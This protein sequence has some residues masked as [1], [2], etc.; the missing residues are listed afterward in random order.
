MST[1]NQP[2]D[3]ASASDRDP[4]A[5]S[6][7]EAN[8]RIAARL[9]QLKGSESVELH[10]ALGRF[11]RVDLTS[12]MHSPPF[13][14]S[15]MD[16]YAY[17]F[18]DQGTTRT[19]V[20]TSLAGHPAQN[21][22]APGDCVR[23]TTGAKIPDDADTVVQQENTSI[24]NDQLNMINPPLKSGHHVRNIGS[25]CEKGR[26]I[27]QAGTRVNAGLLGLCAALGVQKLD[28]LSQ[29]RVILLSTGDELK[30]GGETLAD[31]Q[32]FDANTPLLTA[33]FDDPNVRVTV[34]KPIKDTPESVHDS[35]THAAAN[36]D[37][38]IT[39]GGVSVGERDH[40]RE[41]MENRG[42]VDLWKVAMKPGRPLSFGVL[43]GK[44]PWF[45]LPG[46]PVSAALTALLF[47]M[48]ALRHCQGL[49]AK[50][51]RVI[52]AVCKDRLEKLPGRVEFQR[53]RLETNSDG[54]VTVSTTGLQDSHILSSLANANCLIRLPNESLGAASGDTVSVIPFE[55]LNQN[56]V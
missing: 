16:G 20:A 54:V 10:E 28:V 56:L 6:I 7:D 55:F 36:A 12:P 41:V 48:P 47:V 50:P 53:G 9:A 43:D 18:S 29:I 44:T 27:A 45:G 13:R 25:D 52:Q 17:R 30:P 40:L 3:N 33:L 46:N 24:D 26:C 2:T 8:T 23:V 5:V 35:L 14:A 11:L 4:N 51:L 38:I 37:I 21:S 22:L 39:T 19:V 32:I 34:G 15:A 1:M 42:G 31:G 49:P